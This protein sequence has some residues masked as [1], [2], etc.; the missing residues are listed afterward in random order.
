M[1][2][3]YIVAVDRGHLRIYAERTA[4]GQRTPG[5]QQVQAMDFPAGRHSYTDRDTDMAGRFPG[6][7]R[8]SAAV[9]GPGNVG[10]VGQSIDER[11]PMKREETRRRAKELAAEID[12]FFQNRTDA[13][14]DF[15]AG[16]ELNGTIL[17]LISPVVRQRLRRTV[18]KD[19]VN[20]RVDE[21]R[22]HF[23]GA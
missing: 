21:V 7:K 13:S 14:W 4:P 22:A 12:A 18:A 6:A 3:H 2:E 11:L 19:I 1:N 20:Q 8:Q 9:G 16:H 23:A 5:L 15:A 10:H 17:E